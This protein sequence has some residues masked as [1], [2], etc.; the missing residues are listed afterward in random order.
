MVK[1]LVMTLQNFFRQQFYLHTS[2]YALP[3]LMIDK[4]VQGQASR[5]FRARQGPEAQQ[6]RSSFAKN[7]PGRVYP[8]SANWGVGRHQASAATAAVAAGDWDPGAVEGEKLTT[9]TYELSRK[10]QELAKSRTEI[11][12]LEN[13]YVEYLLF[14]WKS[15]AV[16]E[17]LRKRYWYYRDGRSK[18]AQKTL[19]RR[20]ARGISIILHIRTP[21]G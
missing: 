6:C 17:S 12:C 9:Q 3:W 18:I 8:V 10:K 11:Q 4:K 2:H 20:Q 16:R 5:C 21:G 7:I 15:F 19:L 13:H 1:H 14:Q